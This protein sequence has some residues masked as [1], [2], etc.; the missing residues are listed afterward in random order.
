MAT[1]QGDGGDGGGLGWLTQA[2]GDPAPAT[3]AAPTGA[4][5]AAEGDSGSD[6]LT[7]AQ[8]SSKKKQKPSPNTTAAKGTVGGGGGG[9]AP[10]DGWMSSGKLGVPT[11]DDS[12]DDETG[13]GAA[14]KSKK[15]KKKHAKGATA[16]AASAPGGWLNSGSLGVPAEDESDEDSGDGSG[17]PILVTIET[18]TEEGIEAITE[19]GSAPALPPW[20]KRWTPPPQPEAVPD[21]AP[22]PASPQEVSWAP[23]ILEMHI[24]S[25]YIYIPRPKIFRRTSRHG[26]LCSTFATYSIKIILEKK[27]IIGVSHCDFRCTT[28]LCSSRHFLMMSGLS[29]HF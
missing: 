26:R 18:Q 22:E 15:K 4:S 16:S 19:R 13:K 23:D 8:S 29:R 25:I 7:I 17:Q 20:A 11:G 14:A 9:A 6:W 2:A 21:A 24:R 28:Q 27:M 5:S 1:G 10:G 3:T 12:D